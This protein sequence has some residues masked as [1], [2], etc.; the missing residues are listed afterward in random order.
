[1][2][3]FQG[4]A[5]TPTARAG[6]TGPNLRSSNCVHWTLGLP[7]LALYPS[8]EGFLWYPSSPREPPGVSIHTHLYQAAP[9]TA[10]HPPQ[11]LGGQGPC[12]AGRCRPPWCRSCGRG[13]AQ[14]RGPPPCRRTRGLLGEQ[15]ESRPWLS[16]LRF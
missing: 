11:T 14:V 7:S 15:P 1:M 13:P 16:L 8:L 5:R 3:L 4:L 6:V 2:R 10:H 9:V 12:P